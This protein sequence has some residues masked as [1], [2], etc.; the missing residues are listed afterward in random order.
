[1]SPIVPRFARKGRVV[2]P[3]VTRFAREDRL[4]SPVVLRLPLEPFVLRFPLGTV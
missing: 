4:A 1:M 3:V 2:S